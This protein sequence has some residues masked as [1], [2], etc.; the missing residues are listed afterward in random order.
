MDS[1]DEL[2]ELLEEVSTL[3]RALGSMRAGL[4]R[5]EKQ[6]QALIEEAEA[7]RTGELDL[8]D[9]SPELT[10]SGGEQAIPVEVVFSTIC[11]LVAEEGAATRSKV[12]ERCA[13]AGLEEDTVVALIQELQ[14]NG[15]VGDLKSRKKRRRS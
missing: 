13:K 12:V 8:Q 6:V 5:V 15:L 4:T 14:Q 2:Y 9:E 10:E 11:E 3:K 7:S 1:R